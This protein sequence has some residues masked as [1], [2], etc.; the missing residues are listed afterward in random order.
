MSTVNQIEITFEQRRNLHDLCRDYIHSTDMG[1]PQLMESAAEM[2]VG[3]AAEK[4][5]AATPMVRWAEGC[6]EAER[7]GVD[8]PPVRIPFLRVR[9]IL[10]D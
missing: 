4:D 5:A 2:F 7:D 9:L 10:F 8:W 6:Q 3:T 1:I